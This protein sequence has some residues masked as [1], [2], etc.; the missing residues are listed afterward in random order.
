MD[1]ITQAIALLLTAIGS[2]GVGVY[3]VKTKWTTKDEENN[4]NF[5][6]LT[7]VYQRLE[8]VEKEVVELRQTVNHLESSLN[9]HK[10]KL[11]LA[12][13]HINDL[14]IYIDKNIKEQLFKPKLPSELKE[15]LNE[16]K[17]C[18]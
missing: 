6:L 16:I 2:G 13:C 9:V 17:K 11:K 8:L 3:L 1:L 18:D 7:Q 4:L 14:D 12:L 10:F 5:N 15:E